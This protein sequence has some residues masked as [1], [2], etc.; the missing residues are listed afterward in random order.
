[1]DLLLDA[2]LEARKR[3]PELSLVLVGPGSDRKPRAR[4]VGAAEGVHIV[5]PVP[6]EEVWDYFHAADLGVLPFSLDPGTHAC[7]PL[8]VLEFG[9]AGKPMLAT[10]L[11]ELERLA[12]PHVRFAAPDREAWRRAFLD[13]STYGKPDAV[14]LEAA[15]RPFTWASAGDALVRAMGL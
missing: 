15:L 9:G 7:L 5:G 6:V 3:R 8:K 12:L 11:R 14:R 10:P 13:E 1:M 2:F 4:D